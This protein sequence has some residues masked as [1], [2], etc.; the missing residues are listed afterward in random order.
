MASDLANFRGT[1]GTVDVQSAG[2]NCRRVN[3]TVSGYLLQGGKITSDQASNSIMI[4]KTAANAVTINNNFDI[5]FTGTG[6]ARIR[7]S[8]G[9]AN[10]LTVGGTFA[11]T[12]TSGTKYLDLDATAATGSR[13]DFT[14]N[15]LDNGGTVRLR[16]GHNGNNAGTFPG[17]YYVSG[18][19]TYASET[20]LVRG[21]V[22]LSSSSGFGAGGDVQLASSTTPAGHVVALYLRNNI[23]LNSVIKTANAS[24]SGVVNAVI[25]LDDG[26]TCTIGQ[27]VNLNSDTTRVH[28]DVSS[29]RLNLNGQLFSGTAARSVSKRGAGTLAL[30]ASVNNHNGNVYVSNG[31]FLVNGTLPSPT[32]EVEANAKIGGRG[33]LSG[34]VNVKGGTIAPGESVGTN[35]Y[36]NLTLGNGSVYEWEIGP[37]QTSHDLIVVT[38]LTIGTGVTIKV[39]PLGS[40]NP[41]GPSV[42]NPAF[43]VVTS[44]SGAN[45][46]SLDL[47]E[48]ASWTG[49][50]V[51]MA[52]GQSVGLVLTPE[53]GVLGM[54]AV[55]SLLALRKRA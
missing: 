23:T 51:T 39:K 18:N 43:V 32:V 31:T 26:S 20:H 38:N 45:N 25:G 27:N 47:S 36:N 9:L 4:D 5:T 40:V 29:G 50:L 1:A 7:S 8:S 53:P 13:I 30:N 10:P 46:L 2:I 3:V 28:F 44:I 21:T 52:D 24:G 12:D 42:T 34:S 48:T 35:W 33:K 14:G 55:A 19:S 22:Y 37:A 16:F 6:N 54:A 49:E 17:E 41:P 11:F 15:L